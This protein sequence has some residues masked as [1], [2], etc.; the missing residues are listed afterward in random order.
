MEQNNPNSL[1]GKDRG[2]AAKYAPIIHF[3]ERE[4]F[5]PVRIGVTILEKPD[6][7]VASEQMA[8]PSFN[9]VLDCQDERLQ[10]VI[11]YAIYWDYDI[12]HLYDLEHIW[13]Y[14]AKDGSVLDC[15]ASFHGDYLKGMFKT[16]DNIEATH[17]NL[18][19]QPGKHAFSPDPKLFEL[20]PNYDSCTYETAGSAG[21]IVTKAFKGLYETSDEIDQL[22]EAYLQKY[23]FRASGIYQ[24]YAL[25]DDLFVS[26]EELRNEVPDRIHR[27]LILMRAELQ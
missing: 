19:S 14:V 11:E 12:E 22:V 10:F 15:E 1:N 8:S 17:V 20:I 23:K 3:D 27:E 2:L 9:R 4:P 25:P 18:Y 7:A 13:V 26:W 24:P 5:Y 16:R 6:I 21:L